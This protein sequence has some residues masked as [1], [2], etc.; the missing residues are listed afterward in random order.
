MA[1]FV[2]ILSFLTNSHTVMRSQ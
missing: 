2:V 1:R